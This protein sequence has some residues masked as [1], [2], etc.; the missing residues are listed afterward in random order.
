M[1]T[2]ANYSV[3]GLFTL[4]VIAACLT[5]VYWFS[6]SG[7]K[8]DR[9]QYQIIFAGPVSGLRTGANVLFNG[10]RVGEVVSLVIDK[11]NPRQVIA[12]IAVEQAT[13]ILSDTSVSLEFQGLTGI[14]A[15]G[16]RGGQAH[17]APIPTAKGE[18]PTLRA[19]ANSMQDLMDSARQI[20]GRADAILAR[21]DE[22]VATNQ[23][24]LTATVKN[25]EKLSGALGE[26][27][28]KVGNIVD[29]ISDFTDRLANVGERIDKILSN[30]ET[31]TG[32]GES[33]GMFKDI[34]SAAT[35]IRTLADNL[36]KRTA[37]LSAGISRF[38]GSGLRDI[39]GLATDGKRTLA[40]IERTLRQI[41][42]N[43]QRFIFGGGTR[44]PDYNGGR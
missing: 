25:V 21:V 35:S 34:A 4:A 37:E 31:I 7:E 6:R 43:P 36:D 8:T 9:T 3:V 10:M 41:E 1:E 44:V 2:K 26:R 38:T 18:L 5:F 27:S 32:G 17:S 28:E 39:Q 22:F 16:L 13:P 40:E 19:D 33:N 11:E 12:R 24:S 14:A 30:V 15:V 23:T 29:D 42:R 20:M